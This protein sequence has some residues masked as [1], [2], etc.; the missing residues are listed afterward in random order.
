MRTQISKDDNPPKKST[1]FQDALSLLSKF[2]KG[3]LI[4]DLTNLEFESSH[5]EKNEKEGETAKDKEHKQEELKEDKP[6]S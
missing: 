4:E 3:N 5:L 6:E 2:H 1:K